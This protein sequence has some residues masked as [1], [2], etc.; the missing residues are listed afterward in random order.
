MLLQECLARSRW[1][2]KSGSV[3]KKDLTAMGG[4]SCTPMAWTCPIGS[5]RKTADAE[6]EVYKAPEKCTVTADGGDAKKDATKDAT[7][8][9]TKEATQSG[10][11]VLAASLAATCTAAALQLAM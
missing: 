4:L 3:D 10:A 8:A 9:A 11:G 5:Y 1:A 6:C 2:A 7:K